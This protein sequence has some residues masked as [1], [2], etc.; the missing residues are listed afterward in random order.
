MYLLI[1][2]RGNISVIVSLAPTTDGRCALKRALST[3]SICA[4]DIHA[5]SIEESTYVERSVVASG[6]REQLIELIQ[7]KDGIEAEL[8]ALGSILESVCRLFA[9]PPLFFLSHAYM[10]HKSYSR[11]RLA[12]VKAVDRLYAQ[13]FIHQLKSTGSERQR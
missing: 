4:M 5:L 12:N 8:R 7:Q 3:V 6:S 1:Y 11:C 10:A 13:K 9:T 2:Q